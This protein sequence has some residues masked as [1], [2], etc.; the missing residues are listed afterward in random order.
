MK[1]K[2]QGYKRKIDSKFDIDERGL[3]D[4]TATKIVVHGKLPCVI[5][6]P[7][8]INEGGE[9][10]DEDPIGITLAS[11]GAELR[12]RKI[13]NLDQKQWGMTLCTE[14]LYGDLTYSVFQ[15]VI[16]SNNDLECPL[17][18]EI[19]D[20]SGELQTDLIT[21]FSTQFINKFLDIYRHAYR[22]K[23][24]WIPFVTYKRLSPWHKM[25]AKNCKGK[26]L[27][28]FGV[29]DYRGTGTAIG[30]NLNETE[31]TELQNHCFSNFSV[32]DTSR[33]T[34]LANRYSVIGDFRTSCVM[35]VIAFEN[36]V[37]REVRK[38]LT[39]QGWD[40]KKID[41][42]LTYREPKSSKLKNISREDALKLVIGDKNFKNLAEYRGY[43]DLVLET[44][45]SIV[46]GR[47]VLIDKD[48]YDQM[49][50][51]TTKIREV[52]YAKLIN[53]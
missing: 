17:N 7:D 46:H 14:D 8:S 5:L 44:R 50:V 40:E 30:N 18:L 47:K 33:Y 41:N 24:D 6:L 21:Q 32:E 15:L 53:Q 49:V 29:V 36:W 13:I 35:L 48:K 10:N 9:P 22:N 1:R 39:N 34:Q 31:I 3:S 25:T 20:K 45:D 42:A 23:K 12:L 43:V 2:I 16:T 4:S 27:W 52:L 38:N 37:F 26:S 51:C 19:C 28:G 11:Y